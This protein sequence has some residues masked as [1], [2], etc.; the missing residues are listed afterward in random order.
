MQRINSIGLVDSDPAMIRAAKN[1]VVYLALFMSFGGLVWGSLLLYFDLPFAALIP[2]GYIVLSFF[3]ILNFSFRKNF[4]T[5]STIQITISMLLPFLLQWQLGGFFASGCVMLWSILSLVGSVILLRGRWVYPNL[6][7]YVCFVAFSYFFDSH[8]ASSKPAILTSEI[9]LVLLTLNILLIMAIVFVLAKIKVDRDNLIQ[10]ELLKL[11]TVHERNSGIEQEMRKQLQTSENRY[12]NLVEESRVLICTHDITG[13]IITIN[14]SGAEILGYHTEEVQGKNLS[15]FLPSE[16]LEGYHS[17]L[18]QIVRHKTFEGFMTVLTR[19]GDRRIFLFRNILVEEQGQN[20]Y[21]MGSAQ[22][23]TEW[24]KSENREGNIR[25][26]LQMVVSSIDDIVIEFDE[27]R[28][29][30]N[31]WCRDEKKLSRP[32]SYY[33]GKT[34][35]EAFSYA[36]AFADKAQYV[37]EKVI[38]TGKPYSAEIDSGILP[39]SLSYL[40]RLNPIIEKD[41]S[42]KRCTALVSDITARK[43]VE[44]KLQQDHALLRTIIDNLPLNVY[45][46]NELSQKVIVN[47]AEWQYVGAKNENELIGRSDY[48]LYPNESAQLSID[49]DKFVLAGQSILGKETINTKKDGSQTHFITSKVPLRDAKSKIIGL[50]GISVD[51]TEQKRR[52]LELKKLS[53]QLLKA[54]EEAENSNR[55]KTIF[56][57]SLSHEVRTPLQGILGFA[58]II[59]TQL[60]SEEKRKQYLGIIKKRTIDLQDIIDSLLDMASLETGEIKPFASL[61]NL[62][63]LVEGV[64]FTLQQDH[65]INKKPI[66]LILKNDLPASS[67]VVIDSLH[68]KQVVVNMTKNGIKFT[69]QGSVTLRCQKT[70]SDYLFSIKDTGIGIPPDRLED[71]FGAFRQAHEGLSR[72]KGGI[73][74]GLAIC[75]KMVDLWGGVIKVKSEPNKGS[76]FSFTVPYAVTR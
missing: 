38:S 14:K 66:K 23:V 46:K 67:E 40:I 42:V 3:N 65:T 49:E 58:E 12:R 31:F 37:Y 44:K 29:F 20:P 34:L 9:S 5:T 30:K 36:P 19:K 55:L 6:L 39:T 59:E 10:E 1:L 51:N 73:G 16:F 15:F 63:E 7:L 41:G 26:E 17:Y 74:L 48:E 76:V 43:L 62:N 25:K 4:T 18:D 28:R 56:L 54:K 75:K 21:I 69:D 61:V 13:N 57:G 32:T 52:E 2:Y 68:F 22:D 47:K 11:Y 53:E 70:S 72:S 27:A 64:F 71:I 60:L 8:F 35:S 50:V 33:I 24:R 45:V